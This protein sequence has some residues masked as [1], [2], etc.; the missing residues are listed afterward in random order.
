MSWLLDTAKHEN[1]FYFQERCHVFWALQSMK[2]WYFQASHSCKF[3]D[4]RNQNLLS[5]DMTTDW[6][7]TKDDIQSWVTRT[8]SFYWRI[9]DVEQTIEIFYV[10]EFFKASKRFKT[11]CSK[12]LISCF[13]S[14]SFCRSASRFISLV[15]NF[16][17]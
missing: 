11:S 5:I 10:L 6:F 13:K 4:R 16:S 9:N 12:A 1:C 3:R 2:M 14:D 15:R 8:V 7:F 17:T